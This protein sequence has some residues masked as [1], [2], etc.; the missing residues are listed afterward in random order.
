MNKTILS[1]LMATGV[2]L[3]GFPTAGSVIACTE[4]RIAFVSD[5][6]RPGALLDH[7]DSLSYAVGL[8]LNQQIKDSIAGYDPELFRFCFLAGARERRIDSGPEEIVP[9]LVADYK[10]EHPGSL[11]ITEREIEIQAM[12]AYVLGM[13]SMMTTTLYLFFDEKTGNP[14]VLCDAVLL[15]VGPNSMGGDLVM[16]FEACSVYLES[17]QERLNDA[18]GSLFDPIE[19]YFPDIEADTLPV[20]SREAGSGC[21]AVPLH[22]DTVPAEGVSELYDGDTLRRERPVLQDK[23]SRLRQLYAMVDSGGGAKDGAY[24]YGDIDGDGHDD[25][26]YI[27]A[28]DSRRVSVL[29]L[30]D[31]ELRKHIVMRE[32]LPYTP[33]ISADE[34]CLIRDGILILWEDTETAAGTLPPC[35][36]YRL[37]DGRLE[38][39]AE[40]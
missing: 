39:V 25:M 14:E 22:R 9:G 35:H 34:D 28:N 29:L 2:L 15:G 21:R 24:A 40:Q 23:Q 12:S 16:D 30:K 13:S 37:R 8:L 27:P 20:A 32:K 18:F 4:D 7:S 10:K 17:S 6:D 5:Q 3:S 31:F 11:K 26:V 19:T 1:I 33:F 36:R 38:P